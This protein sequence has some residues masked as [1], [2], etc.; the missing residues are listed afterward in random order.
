[1]M[2]H[3]LSFKQFGMG[4]A[5]KEGRLDACTLSQSLSQSVSLLSHGLYPI[6]NS[7]KWQG[8][9]EE[10]FT[11]KAARGEYGQIFERLGT[12]KTGGR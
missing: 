8:R 7:L 10:Q 4:Y 2:I 3:L 11:A 1:M 12:H 6:P 9:A 5:R